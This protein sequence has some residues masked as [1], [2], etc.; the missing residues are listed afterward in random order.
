MQVSTIGLDIAKNVF[1]LVGQ[2]RAGREVLKKRLKRAQVL[3]YFAQL[4]ACVV[5]IEACGGAHHWAREL[6]KLGHEAKLIPA[7]VVKGYVPGVKNDYNDAAGICEAATRP[8]VRTVAVKTLEQHDI[9]TLHRMRAAALKQRTGTGNRIRGLLAEYG[10]VF[11]R[12]LATL[13]KALPEVLEDADNALSALARELLAG[14]LEKLRALDEEVHG[15]DRRLAQVQRQHP[16]AKRLGEVRGIGPVTATALVGA[17]G[18]GR[19]FR[20]GRA[21]SAAL[22]LVP[23]QHTS[24]DKPMLLGITKRGD[25]Y[26]RTLLVHGARA[27]L[28]HAAGHDDRL[29]RWAL[30]LAAR[31][32]KHKAT[33][34][35]A[36]KLAR[37][38]WVVLA[39]EEPFDPARA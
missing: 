13:R 12:G 25:P 1:H 19:Q 29:S 17:L 21:M 10:V 7:Q 33:V 28:S 34:A 22:G 4:E 35:L 18:D 3:A 26:L 5:G 36:N 11:G 23:G 15:Y 31:R 39:R 30:E 16:A 27:L 20:N 24:G 8:R 32:G 9:Q 6:G 2:N 14:Q 38:A 37:I